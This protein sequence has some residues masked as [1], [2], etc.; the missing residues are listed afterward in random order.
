L[1]Q[2]L[3]K[4]PRLAGALLFLFTFMV[5]QGTLAGSFVFDDIPQILE[6]PFVRNPRL[7]PQ[8]FLGSVWS[9]RGP[10]EHDYMYRPL[11]FAVY[12]LLCRLGGPDPALFHFFHLLIYA[13]TVWLVFHVG[14]EL[15]RNHL[16]A[17]AGAL[18]WAL[19]PTHVETAA[20]I[21]ALPDAGS[22]F[23]Y[24]LGFWLFLRGE[25]LQQHRAARHALAAVAYLVS[26]FFKEMALSFPLLLVAYGLYFPPQ[27]SW[28][29]R[30][31]RWAPYLGAVAC[32]VAIRIAVLGRFSATGQPLKIPLRVVAAAAGLLGQHAK[33][34]FWPT[35][36]SAFRSFDLHA[37]LTSPWPWL[38]V[39]VLAAACALGKRRP[40]LAFLVIAWAVMLL[41]CLDI[42]Q[43]SFPLADRLSFLPSVPLCFALAYV[44]LIWLPER[45]PLWRYAPAV[46]SAGM[47]LVSTLWAVQDVRQIPHWLENEA[48][49]D[50]SVQA[51]PNT[52]LVH[53]FR[54]TILRSRYSDLDGATR[55]FETALRL[56][57]ASDRRL[58]GVTYDCY[59]GLGEIS[60][61]RDRLEEARSYYERAVEIAPSHAPAYK[62][63]GTLYFPRGDYT[64]AAR[65]FAQ[66]VKLDP[67]DLEA[68]FF[69]GTCWM[70]LGKPREAAKQF[71]AAREV[72]PTYT[73]AYQAE[74]R[75]LEAAGD[76]AGA[77]QVRG[78]AQESAH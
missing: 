63:L 7:W 59:L 32:Y 30:A 54:A 38:T 60:N 56:N 26:L 36:L 41:P 28:A 51:S 25:N 14:V 12:W 61:A 35:R 2:Q 52:A 78:L 37:S 67:Q 76:A 40:L 77:A 66:A 50:Y 75:A 19:H 20:W 3:E 39:L 49:W 68:R 69:L 10:A 43:V 27:E 62:A 55:E 47:A 16:A 23:F 48:L 8:I 29:R 64:R 72:D 5:F 44:G 15:L 22:A 71:H 46:V 33:L 6:N 58:V 4:H 1:N 53:L 21:S 18:L 34:F 74:A 9:F 17:F 11:Q 42:R 65:Y 13:A 57:Q 31:L 24:L 45:A 73:Q 70:K